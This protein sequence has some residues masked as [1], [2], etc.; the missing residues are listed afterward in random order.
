MKQIKKLSALAA[1]SMVLA[2]L[3]VT[4]MAQ[5]QV[6]CTNGDTVTGIKG[7]DVI[8]ESYNVN[9]IDVTFT[10]GTAYDI[11]G[12]NLDMPFVPPW[13]EDDPYSIMLS[14]NK[15]LNEHTSVPDSAGISG[16]DSYYIG[17]EEE[18]RGGA[19]AIGAVGGANYTGA[20]WGVCERESAAD[21]LLGVG[22]LQAD[23]QFVYADLSQAV[24][25]ATC[26]TDTGGPPP[27]TF[28][29]TPGITGS[30][31][32][33]A[34]SGEG[35]SIEVYGNALDLQMLAYFYTY[36]AA[37]NQMWLIGSGPINGDTAVLP[38]TVTSGAMF[39]D[40]FDPLDV[41]YVDWGTMTFT[42]SSCDAGKVDFTSIM[43]NGSS[44]FV[45]LSTVTGLACP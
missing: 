13:M 21:C 12:P 4:N 11:Y 40:A 33:V 15:A 28:T 35:Y 18:S 25:G 45:R 39:G 1:G 34:R 44:D 29:I 17:S 7:L 5:A 3:L 41:D 31:F 38:M 26:D 23:Q 14:I 37:G 2:L 20:E 8:I 36:D 6:I 22:V 30:W 16:Q 24:A 42:F 43:G 10:W 9:T 19:A 27:A 32:N